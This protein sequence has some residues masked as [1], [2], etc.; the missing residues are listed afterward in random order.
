MQDEQAIKNWKVRLE[1]NP[2]FHLSVDCVIFGYDDSIL[3]VLLMESDIPQYKGKLSLVGTLLQADQTLREAAQKVLLDSTGLHDMYLEQVEAFS[4]LDRHPFGRVL[5]IAYYSL[6]IISQNDIQDNTGAQLRWVPVSELS[7]MAFD[8]KDIIDICHSILKKKLRE[9]PI[10][11]NLLPQKFSIQQLQDLY[12]A[13][14]GIKLDKRNF[15]RKLNTLNVLIDLNEMQGSVS[16]RPAKLY[17]FDYH[18]MEQEGI[19]FEL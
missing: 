9:S 13:V 15:R 2:Q 10:G 3:K 18:K 19:V 8:H 7:E 6:I 14:L 16:H 4:A 1:D 11:F 5:T 17:S 12:E